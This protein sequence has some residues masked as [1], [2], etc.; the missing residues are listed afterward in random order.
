MKTNDSTLAYFLNQLTAFDKRLHEPLYSVTW[1]RDINLR[2]GITM[3]NESSTFL[4]SNFAAV[5]TT[6]VSGMPFI[7]S[8][9]TAMPGITID[10]EPVTTPIR[11]LG[12]KLAWTSVELERSQLT[13]QPIDKAKFDAMQSMYQMGIDRMVYVGRE[14]DYGL[15]NSPL[16]T[17]GTVATGSGGGTAWAGKKPEEILADVNTL[18][19]GA[20]QASGYAVCPEKLLLPPENF[21][22]ISTQKVSDAGSVSILTYLEDNSISLRTNGRKLEIVP[23]KWLSQRGAGNT[24]R[25]VAYTNREDFV[26]FPMVPIRRETP[27]FQDIMFVSPYIW[28]MGGVEFVYPE[29]VRYA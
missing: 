3:A 19:T 14:Q 26:R 5:G 8:N 12:Y 24:G 18:I 15:A 10:G 21:A 16:I 1:G 28:A 23:V 7:T 22:Y 4:R 20:W 13:G 2:S 27:Y 9:T 25:M 29:T 17:V 11:L 6:N